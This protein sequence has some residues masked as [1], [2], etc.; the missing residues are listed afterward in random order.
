MIICDGVGEPTD[1]CYHDDNIED[2]RPRRHNT[3]IKKVH[4]SDTRQQRR[5]DQQFAACTPG[6]PSARGLQ[7][8]APFGGRRVGGELHGRP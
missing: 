7:P 1:S 4:K 8:E 5:R 2:G 3:M 6:R